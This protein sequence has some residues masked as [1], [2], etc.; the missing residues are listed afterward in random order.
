MERRFGIRIRVRKEETEKSG[1]R[2]SEGAGWEREVFLLGA[3][4]RQFIMRE[5]EKEGIRWIG[6]LIV[7]MDCISVVIC[8]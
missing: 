8:M 1:Q 4:R 7:W 6:G 2:Q 3:A 5:N